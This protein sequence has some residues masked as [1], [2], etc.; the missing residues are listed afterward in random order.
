MRPVGRR[1]SHGT[2]PV[3]AEVQFKATGS[4]AWLAV[5]RAT[6][7][8]SGY[9]VLHTKERRAGAFRIAFQDGDKAVRTR[10]AR[11]RVSR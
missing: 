11:V 3:D 10:A 8:S 1:S 7:N 5:E 4:A 9:V 6:T 2:G